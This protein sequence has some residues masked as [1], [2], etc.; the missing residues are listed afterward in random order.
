M[1]L[2]F[3]GGPAPEAVETA[4]RPRKRSR[5]TTSR[6]RAAK[7]AKEETR[8]F[9]GELDAMLQDALN[10]ATNYLD[11]PTDAPRR[12]SDRGLDAIIRDTVETSQVEIQK[13]RPKRVTFSFDPDK[14]EA[15]RKIAK[16][17]KAYLREVVDEIVTDY[18]RRKQ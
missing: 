18:L 5:R 7:K 8:G 15:L 1:D 9:A 13:T 16:D 6:G 3:G 17:K 11:E 10:D 4:P 14:L 2:L 12:G